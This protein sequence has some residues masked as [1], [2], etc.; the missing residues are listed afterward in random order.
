MFFFAPLQDV[1]TTDR[2]FFQADE[3][4]VSPHAYAQSL[5]PASAAQGLRKFDSVFDEVGAGEG[6]PV[7]TLS[8]SSTSVASSC[9]N[10]EMYAP[11]AASGGSGLTLE[12]WDDA[13]DAASPTTLSL[14]LPKN[15]TMDE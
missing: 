6:A 11:R 9:G 12:G 4:Q 10:A 5:V 1:T 8:T 15:A 14:R 7:E 2:P 13:T 3:M